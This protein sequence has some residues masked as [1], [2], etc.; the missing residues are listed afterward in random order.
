MLQPYHTSPTPSS[1]CHLLPPNQH[2]Q[3][4]L[5]QAQHH[6]NHGGKCQSPTFFTTLAQIF[7]P[8]SPQSTQV[9]SIHVKNESDHEA[10]SPP[11]K[12]Q[13]SPWIYDWRSSLIK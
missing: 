9:Y 7:K 10:N 2:Q 5:V 12:R 11:L 4:C 3:R 8:S 6:N 13:D 1:Q